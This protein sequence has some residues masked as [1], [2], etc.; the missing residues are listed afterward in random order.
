MQG[1]Q[2][3]YIRVNQCLSAEQVVVA[4]RP[5]GYGVQ[6]ACLTLFTALIAWLLYLVAHPD[7]LLAL[8][9]SCRVSMAGM[10]GCGRF[11]GSCCCTL[12]QAFHVASWKIRKMC[13]SGLGFSGVYVEGQG[14]VRTE[15]HHH[16]EL[17]TD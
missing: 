14:G 15:P 3:F 13:S 5:D 7:P 8:P 17:N 4:S 2:G 16:I 9:G 11:G 10:P 12:L 6:G 1:A